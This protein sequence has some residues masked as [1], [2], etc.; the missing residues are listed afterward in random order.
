[1]YHT[2][3]ECRCLTTQRHFGSLISLDGVECSYTL[4]TQ[5][6]PPLSD[7]ILQ[8]ILH[9]AFPLPPRRWQW[10]LNARE[11]FPSISRMQLTSCCFSS[12]RRRC[13]CTVAMVE[14]TRTCLRSELGQCRIPYRQHID[15]DHC[16]SAHGLSS[17]ALAMH[18]SC[19]V[20][21]TWTKLGISVV[22]AKRCHGPHSRISPLCTLRS[23]NVS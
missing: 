20:T 4:S 13:S 21:K 19:R 3:H 2:Y 9:F 11:M 15:L 16:L 12:M 5:V 18:A 6:S 17:S 1:M 23:D 8:T 7:P 22:V 14:S 10:P